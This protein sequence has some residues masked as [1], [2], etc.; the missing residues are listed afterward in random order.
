MGGKPYDND[1]YLLYAPSLSSLT[2]CGVSA[3]REWFSP[4]LGTTTSCF[5]VEAQLSR[6]ITRELN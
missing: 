5:V 1:N 2:A 3:E 6:T 4:D